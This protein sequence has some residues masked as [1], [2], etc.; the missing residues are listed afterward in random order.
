MFYSVSNENLWVFFRGFKINSS[1]VLHAQKHRH[2]PQTHNNQCKDISQWSQ[3]VPESTWPPHT[4]IKKTHWEISVASPWP[5]NVPKA[6][7][8][9]QEAAQRERSTL[10][11]HETKR[12]AVSDAHRGCSCLEVLVGVHELERE[13]TEDVLILHVFMLPV[14]VSVH[15]W[16]QKPHRALFSCQCD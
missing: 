12:E 5:K 3:T 2:M 15:A 10:M 11:T 13:N 16:W 1:H 9:E 6:T 4:H 7:T 14:C 8:R